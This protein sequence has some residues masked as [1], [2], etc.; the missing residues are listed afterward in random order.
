MRVSRLKRV[1]N[2]VRETRWVVWS[3]TD[4]HLVSLKLIGTWTGQ[5]IYSWKI[6]LYAE[7]RLTLIFQSFKKRHYV[8]L[9]IHGKIDVYANTRCIR[10]NDYNRLANSGVWTIGKHLCRIVCLCLDLEKQ[11]NNTFLRLRW[12]E[13]GTFVVDKWGGTLKKSIWKVE[14][15]TNTNVIIPIWSKFVGQ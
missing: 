7:L 3:F 11:Q 15:F 10:R 2:A 1:V 13:I 12:V 4:A 9:A 8:V 6:S 5:E 14:S